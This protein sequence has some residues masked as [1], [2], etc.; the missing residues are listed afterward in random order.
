MKQRMEINVPHKKRQ[1]NVQEQNAFAQQAIQRSAVWFRTHLSEVPWPIREFLVAHEIDLASDVDVDFEDMS[2]LGLEG[3]YRGLV[4]KA[5]AQFWRW[6]LSLDES[7]TSIES[8]GAWDDVTGQHV[9]NE[10]APGIGKNFAFLCLEV[11]AKLNA[12]KLACDC[13]P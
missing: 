11:L 13:R 2:S 1:L 7:R 8:I 4:V 5:D 12:D 6:E 10:H 9:P 3:V